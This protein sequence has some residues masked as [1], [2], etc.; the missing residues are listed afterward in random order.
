LCGVGLLALDWKKNKLLNPGEVVLKKKSLFFFV[1]S[2]RFFGSSSEYIMKVG[3]FASV[4]Q[5]LGSSHLL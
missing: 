5:G 4:F 1:F 3:I 2:L